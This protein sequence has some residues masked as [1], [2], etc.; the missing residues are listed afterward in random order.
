MSLYQSEVV[1][2]PRR[3]TLSGSAIALASSDFVRP[4]VY[5]RPRFWQRAPLSSEVLAVMVAAVDFCL[6]SATAAGAFNLYFDLSDR[7]AG[8]SGR[9]IWTTLFAATLFVGGFERF[10]GYRLTQLLKLHWQLTRALAMW[11][12]MLSR[13]AVGRGAVR[14]HTGGQPL[15]ITGAA[16]PQPA[17]LPCVCDPG[18]PSRSGAGG[19]PYRGYQ[20]KHPLSCPGSPSEGLCGPGVRSKRPAGYQ[21]RGRRAFVFADLCRTAAGSGG[22]GCA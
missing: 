1:P 2:D 4:E 18:C 14:P 12:M 6:V 17:C 22:G 3:H 15:P 16:A 7:S 11:S 9:Y 10:G 20:D 19:A 13:T 21:S 5:R 8:E